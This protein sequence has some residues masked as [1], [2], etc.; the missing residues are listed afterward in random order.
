[1]A[2]QTLSPEQSRPVLGSFLFLCD[3]AAHKT[4]PRSVPPQ[5]PNAHN[6]TEHAMPPRIILAQGPWE[7]ELPALALVLCFLIAWALV[8]LPIGWGIYRWQGWQLSYPVPP[9]QKIPLLLS[10][11]WIAPVLLWLYGAYGPGPRVGTYGV[12]WDGQFGHSLA[13]GAGL[14]GVG[15]AVLVTLQWGAG[16]LQRVPKTPAQSPLQLMATAVPI[17]LLALGISWVEELVFRGFMVDQ[18]ATAYPLWLTVLLA[19]AIF[20]VL[21]L[22]WDGPGASPQ[23]PGLWLLGT[24]LILARWA[25]GGQLGL[26]CGLHGGWIGA[27]AFMD[28]LGLLERSPAAPRFLGRADLPLTNTLTL[29]LLVATGGGMAWFGG[30]HP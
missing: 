12:A 23:L 13:L 29:G 22:L 27:L 19:S 9:E 14:G 6:P 18:L 11:Y 30:W 15:I 24:V 5:R 10:L 17:A 4:S 7:L 26:A 28:T 20:A 21:H 2:A 3:V 16:W 1:M 25:D 8:W